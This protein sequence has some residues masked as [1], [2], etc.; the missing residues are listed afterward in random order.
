MDQLLADDLFPAS[1]CIEE[2]TRHWT[3]LLSLTE[4]FTAFHVNALNSILYQK[5]RYCYSTE[6]FY[7]ISKKNV[8]LP[9]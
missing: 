8:L 6:M 3:F 9:N 7:F 5:R 2:R 4:N 1:L